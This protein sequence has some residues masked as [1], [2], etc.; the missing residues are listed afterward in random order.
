MTWLKV[1]N[2]QRLSLYRIWRSMFNYSILQ[3]RLVSCYIF[4]LFKDPFSVTQVCSVE[5][6]GDKWMM[7]WKGFG[8]KLSWPNLRFCPR[9]WRDWGKPRELRIAGFRA[10]TWTRDF[11][12]TGVNHSNT[13][14]GGSVSTLVL[15]MGGFKL[16]QN[17]VISY[18][19]MFIPSAMKV[20][21]LVLLV[22]T[23]T[24]FAECLLRI[25]KINNRH[26]LTINE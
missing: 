9:I 6:R 11:G 26:V 14:F 7:N 17:G 4:S 16:D 12:N 3:F 1:V 10:E 21:R 15:L 20:I 22:W 2:F 5:W 18:V 13:T 25:H 23:D 19:V 8:R 24:Q